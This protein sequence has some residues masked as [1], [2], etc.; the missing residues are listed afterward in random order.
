MDFEAWIL[1]VV[2]GRHKDYIRAP[3]IFI[4]ISNLPTMNNFLTSMCLYHKSLDIVNPCFGDI[5]YMADGKHELANAHM[6]T[7]R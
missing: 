3:K 6:Y 4:C 5:E 2:I 1:L 7:Q